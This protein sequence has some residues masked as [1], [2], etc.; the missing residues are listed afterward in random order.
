MSCDKE[1]EDKIKLIYYKEVV[2]PN[3]ED[4]KNL[5]VLTNVKK[6]INIA[7]IRTNYHE[8]HGETYP[9]NTMQGKN[10]SRL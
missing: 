1:L 3:L 9:Q 10:M 7:K 8:L 2:S 6:R 5:F 4:Q